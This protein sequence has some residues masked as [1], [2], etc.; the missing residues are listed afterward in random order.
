[1]V[2]KLKEKLLNS[3]SFF[4]TDKNVIIS[5]VMLFIGINSYL[6]SEEIYY[7]NFLP[8][9]L[10]VVYLAF[11]KVDKLILITV[12][13]VPLSIPLQSIVK[14]LDYDMFLP[15]EPI[16]FGVLLL[17]IL[18]IL[19]EPGA[20]DKRII[21][22][23]ITIFIL[24]QTAWMVLTTFSSTMTLVSIK[25]TVVRLWF[26][27]SFYFLTI[28]MFRKKTNIYKYI[29]IY[30]FAMLI[31]ISYTLYN[32]LQEG[33]INQKAAHG[34]MQ[35]FFNDHTS[36][37]AMIAMLLPFCFTIAFRSK[38]SFQTKSIFFIIT[39]YLIFAVI[40]SYTRAAWL[41]LFGII[42]IWFIIKSGISLKT[43]LTVSTVVILIIAFNFTDIMMSLERNKQDSSK[44]IQSHLKSISNVRSDASNLERINRWKSAFR[45]FWDKPVFGFGPGT[46]M[47]QYAP[48]QM[49]YEKTIISTNMANGGNAHSEYI[50]PM[51][52]QGLF[53]GIAFVGV[54]A[55]ILFYGIRIY[56]RSKNHENKV[57]TISLS[58][59]LCTYLIHGFLNNFLDTDKASA[60]YWGFAA[61][62]VALDLYHEDNIEPNKVA[63]INQK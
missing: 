27:S 37:A 29:I 5:I 18:K 9:G 25:Y 4:Q 39:S 32:H 1:M 45:M 10:L 38:F 51:A 58:L 52:E 54:S 57:I 62:I 28:Y 63:D 49:S 42:V 53:G 6:I 16:L 56:R 22:H 14:G 12:F 61:A 24:V 17:F 48:Y 59:G 31:V 60:L 11:Y 13:C 21:K 50:G 47:F 2:L 55:S 33:L 8:I 43:F 26:L 20:M 19:L 44:D 41:S 40:F 30:I 36:Y 3:L 7:L 34:S 35:P 23:P 46:Y 15:T